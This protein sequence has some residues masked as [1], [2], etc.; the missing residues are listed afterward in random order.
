MRMIR[1]LASALFILAFLPVIAHAATSYTNL[2][3]DTDA[4]NNSNACTAAGAG[5]ACATLAG[6][7]AKISANT[8]DLTIHCVGATADTL[9]S[10]LSITNPMASHGFMASP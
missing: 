10:T 5:N 1:Y 6:A 7:V 4:G 9:T 2:Y 8:V 3:V